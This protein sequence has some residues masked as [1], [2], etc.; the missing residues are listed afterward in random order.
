MGG[1]FYVA[2]NIRIRDVFFSK[3]YASARILECQP[4]SRNISHSIGVSAKPQEHQPQYRSISQIRET[5]A[6]I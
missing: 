6:T 1:C 5:S 4:N 2:N 3:L